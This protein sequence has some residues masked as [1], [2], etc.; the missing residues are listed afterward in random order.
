MLVT[1]SRMRALST[2]VTQG[3]LAGYAQGNGGQA[4]P[5]WRLCNFMSEGTPMLAVQQLVIK[6]L[7]KQETELATVQVTQIS[8]ILFPLVLT[9]SCC[10]LSS[11][12]SL[13]H[14]IV[15]SE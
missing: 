9:V 3:D 11:C 15:I 8:Y 7:F 10:L 4:Y 2:H 12:T 1:S 14:T 6:G 5:T 13:C